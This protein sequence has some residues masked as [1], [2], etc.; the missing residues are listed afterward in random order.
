MM[1]EKL[2]HR[3]KS[4]FKGDS[5]GLHFALN[6]FIGT[7]LVWI[8]VWRCAGQ[9]PIWAISSMVAA[10]DPLVEEAFKTFRGRLINT[11]IGCT[12]GL[13]VLAVGGKSEW[14]IPIALSMSVLISS[15]LVRVRVMFRQ[16]PITAAIVVAGGL[17]GHSKLNGVAEG[18]RRV[19]EVLLGCLV[20]LAVTWALSK[21]WP[22]P[23][24]AEGGGKTKP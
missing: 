6:I 10:S 18:V 4:P 22:P 20:G 9:D 14:N 8:L 12:A 23:E 16:A 24:G 11:L 1:V 7:T 5:L 17:T 2:M 15:Y 3:F 21:I 13:F 19:G